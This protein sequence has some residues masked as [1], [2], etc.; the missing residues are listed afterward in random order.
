MNISSTVLLQDIWKK[1][2]ILSSFCSSTK[3]S[4]AI[5]MTLFSPIATVLQKVFSYI[6]H[7]G[8]LIIGRHFPNFT[9]MDV[10][11]RFFQTLDLPWKHGD[12]RRTNFRFNPACTLPNGMRSA[13]FP[14]P[15]STKVLH[16]KNA[17]A[18]E[19]IFVQLLGG[20]SQSA[21]FPKAYVDHAQAAVVWAKIGEGY[22]VYDGNV[23]RAEG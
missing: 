19:K 17:R 21:V 13:S 4:N 5:K 6:H 16:V 3:L 12:Y 22:L 7:G 8:L 15:Y 14:D 11:G 9:A 1:A 10:F 20:T 2:Q 18:E 23:N